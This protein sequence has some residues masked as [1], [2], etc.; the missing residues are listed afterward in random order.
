MAKIRCSSQ[1]ARRIR[2]R[3]SESDCRPSVCS[4]LEAMPNRSSGC[5]PVGG[6]YWSLTM[7]LAHPKGE[8]ADES[9]RRLLLDD[10]ERLEYDCESCIRRQVSKTLANGFDRVVMAQCLSLAVRPGFRATGKREK[11][12]ARKGRNTDKAAEGEQLMLLEIEHEAARPIVRAAKSYIAAKHDYKLAG[13]LKKTKK[14][15]L[16]E[17]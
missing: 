10:C 9:G 2:Q 7:T 4:T 11:D 13:Q 3:S 14:D 6:P 1:K 15:R 5:S 8:P 16:R 12:M 17:L